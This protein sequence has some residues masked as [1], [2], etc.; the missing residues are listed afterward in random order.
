MNTFFSKYRNWIFME[1]YDLILFMLIENLDIT[2]CYM[3]IWRYGFRLCVC[4]SL[5]S[6]ITKN[7]PQKNLQIQM[8][9]KCHC[10]YLLNHN[11]CSSVHPTNMPRTLWYLAGKVSSPLCQQMTLQSDWK[12][13]HFLSFNQKYLISS[14]RRFLRN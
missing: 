3:V 14:L 1:S 12:R 10:Q 8:E 7:T 2:F 9:E 5:T 4:P 11:I 6:S 13:L